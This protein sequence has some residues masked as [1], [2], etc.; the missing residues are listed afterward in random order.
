[1]SAY[2]TGRAKHRLV[3]STSLLAVLAAVSARLAFAAEG[4]DKA[5]DEIVVTAEKHNS[6]VQKT[7]ISMTA[8]SGSQLQAQGITDIETLAQ[9]VPGISM[10]TAG[11]GQTEYEMRGLSSA[12]GASPTVGFYLDETPMTAPA[13]AGNGKVVIDPDLFDLNRV[14]ILRGPQGTLYGSGS[15]GGTIKLVTNAPQLNKY[16][17]AIDASLSGTPG[18]GVNPGLSAMLNLP[19]VEDKVALRIVGTDK[20]TSGW[21]DRIVLNPFPIPTNQGCAPTAFE[22]C[23]RGNIAGAPVQ[24]DYRG[25]NWERLTSVRGSLLI[26]PVEDLS[27]QLGAFYQRIKQGGPNEYDASSGIAPSAPT[28][29][30]YE[31]YNLPEPFVDSYK[32]FS[33][34][35]TYDLPFATVTSATSYWSR[36]ETQNQDYSQVL[37]NAF[38]LS[39]YYP[40]IDKEIDS[41]RQFSE[42]LR[43]ASSGDGPFQWVGGAFY[44]SFKSIYDAAANNAQLCSLSTGGCAANPQGIAFDAYDPYWTD[45]E[46]LFGEASYKLTDTLK[47]TMGVRGFHFD[48]KGSFLV[49]GILTQTGNATQTSSVVRSHDSGYNPKVNL[50]YTPSNDLTVYATVAKGFRPGGV[51]EPVPV[52]GPSSCLP[53]LLDRGLDQV[54]SSYGPDTVWNYEL[55]EKAQLFG[56]RVTIN[57]DFFYLQWKGVQLTSSLPC[58]YP[59]NSN[60]GDGVSYGPE[61]EVAARLG[62]GFVLTLSGDY[63]HA[64]LTQG[65]ITSGYASGSPILNVPKYNASASL[66]YDYQISNLYALKARV[67][68]A[69]VG[70]LT[71]V[72]YYVQKLP[73]YDLTDLRLSLLTGKW[74]GTLFVTNVTDRR[75]AL[76]IDNTNQTFNSPDVTRVSTNQPRTIGIDLQFKF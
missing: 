54:P 30:H 35:V 20:Y 67:S 9:E 27:I 60:A 16:E 43:L 1:M 32:L 36:S 64:E 58:G 26:T 52:S 3:L 74:T 57:S 69:L 40:E 41:S 68:N 51:N 71:D 44:M 13:A 25:V 23:N 45:E 46:A 63:D 4:D 70:P 49:N 17:G 38:Y 10:R 50:S 72:A 22:G 21:I 6:T 61:L 76:T 14:E 8:I 15:M 2:L 31:P 73:S 59:Y 42:E 65:S 28:L 12:G 34:T 55:G 48:N 7:P 19:L 47:L 66:T 56:G 53:G 11:P 24:A 39:Q 33:G 37:Q 75:A 18:S 29:A 5:L 62:A